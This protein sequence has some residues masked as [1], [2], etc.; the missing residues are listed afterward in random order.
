MANIPPPM[1]LH[2]IQLDDPAIDV[3]IS[4]TGDQI[5][6]LTEE[7]MSVYSYDALARPFF[8]P[9]LLKTFQIRKQMNFPRS[10]WGSEGKDMIIFDTHD[11]EPWIVHPSEMNEVSEDLRDRFLE[12]ETRNYT[13]PWARKCMVKGQVRIFA[14]NAFLV[15]TAELYHGLR[16]Y[17]ISR[18][19]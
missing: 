19:A 4:D 8:P 11:A 2:E 5:I 17:R 1:S 10:L 14:H 6:V 18:L 15:L 9:S 13:L 7:S 12:D 3:K 16:Y